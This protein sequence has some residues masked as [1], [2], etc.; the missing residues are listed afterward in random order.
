MKIAYLSTGTNVY[1]RRFLKKMIERGYEA[2]LISYYHEQI[3]VKIEGVQ[4]LHYL[5]HDVVRF[6]RLSGLQVAFH[7][8]KVLRSIKPDILHTGYVQH[9][10][11]Y[12]AL[13]GF[14]P[15]LLMPWGSDILIEPGKSYYKRMVTKFTIKKADIIT[16]DCQVVK[17]RIIELTGYPSEKIVIFPWGIDLNTF[18]PKRSM[19]RERLGWDG[20]K[21]LIMTRQF[22]PIYGIEYFIE[23]LP[24]IIKQFP[25]TKVIFV[26]SGPLEGEYRE[27][28]KNLG[29]K[30]YVLFTGW[31]NETEMADY[32]NASDI[33]VSTSLSDGASCSLLEAMACGLPVV[34]SDVPAN[35]EWV[36]NVVNGYIVPRK[37]SA[38]FAERIVE[39]L[40]NDSL[41]EHMGQHNL[42]IAQKR[43]NWDKNFDIL[44]GIY[45]TLTTSLTT[46]SGV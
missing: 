19:A 46:L 30:E 14:H 43:A 45:K 10:G 22:E 36:E 17:D 13:T 44:E 4:V 38:R 25:D 28:I 42:E 27:R 32:L 9:H 33:Y 39:L 8:R 5:Y 7:L 2:Y 37:D 15:T 21:I 31:V 12:G 35:E 3:D 29:L 34:V 16:C 26:G 20:K 41:R 40:N 6:N 11:Y 24:A 18:Q 23:A 1:D